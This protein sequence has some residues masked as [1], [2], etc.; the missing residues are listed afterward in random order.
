M[1]TKKKV[2]PKKPYNADDVAANALHTW[3]TWYE[4][5][6]VPPKPRAQ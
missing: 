2:E 5:G 6:R 1:K 4:N 3:K